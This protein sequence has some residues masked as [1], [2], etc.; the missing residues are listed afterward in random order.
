MHNNSS[1]HKVSLLAQQ[2]KSSGSFHANLQ[3]LQVSE[4]EEVAG[5]EV[6]ASHLQQLKQQAA[7]R[8]YISCSIQERELKNGCAPG[9][10]TRLAACGLQTVLA[11]SAQQC[12]LRYAT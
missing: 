4:F 8:T 10:Y 6:R 7:V 3:G 9:S 11:R 5:L 2:L 12:Y 1:R